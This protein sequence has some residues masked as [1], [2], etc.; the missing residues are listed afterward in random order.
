MTKAR[1]RLNYSYMK[2]SY[3]ASAIGIFVLIP[4]LFTV[5]AI[6]PT[7]E[8]RP[9]FR[10]DLHPY[11]FKT[12]VPGRM[13]RNFTD[14]TFLSDDLVLVTVNTRVFGPVEN[15]NSDQ[16]PSKLLLFDISRGILLKSLE[17]PVEKAAGSVKGIQGGR[18]ALLSESG[19][20]ICSSYAECG[21]PIDTRGPLFVSPKGTRIAVG[22][23]GQEEQK[24]LDAASLREIG[25][26]SGRDQ[27]IIPGDSGILIRQGDKLYTRQPG[28]PDRPVP[29][30]GRGIWPEAR[31]IN[32]T[33]IAD[34]DSDKS[35][36]IARIGGNILFRVPVKTRWQVAEV[37][38][39]SSGSRF[40]FHEAGYTALNSAINFLDIDNGRPFDFE[41]V[42]ILS[43]DSGTSLFE[44]RWDP[45][46]YTG[47]LQ[48]PALSPNGRRL[49]LIRQGFLEVFEV[50]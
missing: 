34:F 49:A 41:T 29:F 50:R 30:G 48:V 16:P 3:K 31:F 33:T 43:A 9:V 17:M 10:Q 14:I 20:R 27:S 8:P 24:L 47:Y 5:F 7:N 35:L 38:T 22:G 11:G 39:A 26:F 15:T 12:E 42:K 1:N 46:P 45:R 32:D 2:S 19:L 18:F 37:T 40:C 4:V 6:R 44:L 25:R 21:S 36:A 13:L 28:Q 23:N